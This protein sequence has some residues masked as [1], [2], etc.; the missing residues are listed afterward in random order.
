MRQEQ[1]VAIAVATCDHH[2]HRRRGELRCC[3]C[4]GRYIIGKGWVRGKRSFGP[5]ADLRC[6]GNGQ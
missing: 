1:I 2:S 5:L 6:K 4:S 3:K